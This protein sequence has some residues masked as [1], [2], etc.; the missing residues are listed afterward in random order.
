MLP[1]D[2]LKASLAMRVHA[3]APSR[4]ICPLV[5]SLR[6]R[7]YVVVFRKKTDEEAGNC[8]RD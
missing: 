4:I 5:R 2:L 3:R 7:A 1:V 6:A 8:A